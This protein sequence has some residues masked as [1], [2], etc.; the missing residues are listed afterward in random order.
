MKN[1]NKYYTPELNEFYVGFE[2]EIQHTDPPFKWQSEILNEDQLD[3]AALSVT[4]MGIFRIKYL[5]KD[6]I[7][8]CGFEEISKFKY[9]KLRG[10]KHKIIIDYGEMESHCFITQETIN[11]EN[12][13]I[14]LFNGYLSNKSE[15]KKLIEKLTINKIGDNYA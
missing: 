2:Y 1:Q 8:E 13:Y 11:N 4:E 10:K 5:D 7:I 6:D 12:N 15:F 9:S 14:V 3:W